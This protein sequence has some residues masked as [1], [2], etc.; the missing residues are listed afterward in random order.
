MFK[1]ALTDV[2]GFCGQKSGP[3]SFI[4]TKKIAFGMHTCPTSSTI[5]PTTSPWQNCH[6]HHMPYA[7]AGAEAAATATAKARASVTDD[8]THPGSKPKLL[9]MP[10]LPHAPG[11]CQH[12]HSLPQAGSS[13]QGALQSESG[14][15]YRVLTTTT[16]P[17][18]HFKVRLRKEGAVITLD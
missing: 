15:G 4:T 2:L 8:T 10:F 1:R 13:S 14:P 6:C 17:P 16:T 18:R 11:S 7:G 12:H 5:V 9:P 3:H